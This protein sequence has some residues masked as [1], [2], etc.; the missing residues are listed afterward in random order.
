MSAV[1][2]AP[3]EQEI[4]KRPSHSD[5]SSVEKQQ[6]RAVTATDVANLE[7]GTGP[8]PRHSWL[9]YERLRPFVL[10]GAILVIL[11]WWIS[12]TILPATRHRWIPQTIW[13][14]FFIL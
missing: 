12:A 2:A 14:W 6:D 7:D 9:T 11:G 3:T 13:A 4:E 5:D 10:V 8:K 1:Q